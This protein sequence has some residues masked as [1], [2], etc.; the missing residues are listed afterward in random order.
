MT[1]R[2]HMTDSRPESEESRV[3]QANSLLRGDAFDHPV[4]HLKLLETHIS[5][6]ILTGPYAYKIKKPVQF[7]FVDY[8]TLARRKHFCDLEL[9]LNR[10]LAPDIYVDVVP[11]TG[12]TAEPRVGGTGPPIDYAVKMVEFSQEAILA[13]R[14]DQGLVTVGEID[15]LATAI[16][17][18][19]RSAESLSPESCYGSAEGILL[20][21][22]K[23]F[24]VFR[25]DLDEVTDVTAQEA[26]QLFRLQ[27]W[28]EQEFEK[29]RQVFDIR[30]DSGATRL[31]HGDMHLGNIVRI[32]DRIEIFD[33]IEFNPG[34][35]WIDCQSELAFPI[36][37]LLH[38]RRADFAN[39]LL[40][41][42]LEASGDYSGLS[43]LPFYLVYRTMV[44][45]KVDRLRQR[46]GGAARNDLPNPPT[47]PFLELATE[48]I[49]PR[50]T[51]LYITHGLSGSGKSTRAMQWVESHGA[52]R[53][54]SDV[55]RNRLFGS[56]E[57]AEKYS[58][59]S[60][61]QVYGRLTDLAEEILDTGYP[62][63]VDATFLEQ[64]SRDQFRALAARM[65][66]QFG[67]IDCRAPLE[68]LKHRIRQRHGDASEA[69]IDVL[70]QQVELQQPLTQREDEFCV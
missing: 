61:Q 49:Q 48:L 44:R 2:L 58:Q 34:L 62:V 52:V 36:M 20:E 26:A 35:Q 22:I 18:F 5:W 7:D 57:A 42:Y 67:I 65:D 6:V 54:R 3:F 28:T 25:H 29:K 47:T 59:E 63:V 4:A 68:Q 51:F 38:H 27:A 24:D 66:T 69:T 14:I 70:M 37:D 55:E 50:P 1:A 17:K 33:G 19:H 30:R 41:Q 16:A 9:K 12:D 8:S 15:E 46:Q 13:H 64:E 11:I 53:I 56:R 43:V 10:R 21:A 23:N 40:N 31:C 45:A 32:G 39:R 60:S